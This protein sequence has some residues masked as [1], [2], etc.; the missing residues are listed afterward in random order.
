MFYPLISSLFLPRN[1]LD[2]CELH[3]LSINSKSNVRHFSRL[4]K[5]KKKYTDKDRNLTLASAIR[6]FTLC[7][8]KFTLELSGKV[9]LQL[10]P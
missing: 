8:P 9:L 7:P 5:R 6:N 3:F 2:S 10:S 1:V 4:R